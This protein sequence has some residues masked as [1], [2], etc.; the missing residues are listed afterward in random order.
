[1]KEKTERMMVPLTK[2]R[3]LAKA[4]GTGLRGKSEFHS[5]HL[6]P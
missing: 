3:G 5:K 6:E 2:I 4:A 1:M